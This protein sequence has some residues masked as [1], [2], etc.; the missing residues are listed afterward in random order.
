MD[1]AL[2]SY[3][4]SLSI[5][6]KLLAENPND[7]GTILRVA[8]SEELVGEVLDLRAEPDRALAHYRRV[9][10][11]AAGMLDMHRDDAA[12]KDLLAVVQ[13]RVD[14]VSGNIRSDDNLRAC[15]STQAR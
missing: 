2:Y 5:R 7:F 1:G 8:R 3:E 4:Q 13:R 12:V 6:S 10:E 9:I 14:L 15:A 11:L